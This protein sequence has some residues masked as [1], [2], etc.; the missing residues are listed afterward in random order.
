MN[1][2]AMAIKVAIRDKLFRTES[3]FVRF[4]SSMTTH[5]NFKVSLG[6]V[7]AF[8]AGKFTF[9]ICNTFFM[10][11]LMPFKLFLCAKMTSTLIIFANES[12]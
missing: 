7:F 3:T 6:K 10:E 5:V 9:V 12:F 11:F 8:A 4:F 1:M 2:E